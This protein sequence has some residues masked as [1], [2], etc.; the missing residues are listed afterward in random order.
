MYDLR[1][2]Q[3]KELDIMQAVHDACEKLNIEYFIC[4]DK[5]YCHRYTAFELI[6]R[7][8]LTTSSTRSYRS[9]A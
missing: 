6:L 8:D 1:G 7:H 2:L 4:S 9:S 3:M 5:Q